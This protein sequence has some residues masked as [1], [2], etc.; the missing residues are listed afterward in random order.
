[1]DFFDRVQSVRRR[2]QT[3]CEQ[4]QRN[5]S[6]VRLVG[7]T[8]Y[9]GPVELAELYRAGVREFGENRLQVAKPKLEAARVN[10][11]KDVTWHFIGQ[12]QTN[13]VKEVLREFTW[14]HS[15][16]RWP[17]ALEVN[18]RAQELG[19]R[20]P[21]LLQIN[22]SG[23]ET[24]AGLAA[25]EALSFLEA[26]HSLSHIQVCGLMTMAPRADVPEEI[27]YVFRGLREL[28]DHLQSAGH[29]GIQELSMGMSQDFE[30]AILEGATIVRIGQTLLPD[31]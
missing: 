13:K 25:N 29:A 30:A 21:C 19:L 18:K 2:I 14:I 24:K 9:I 12:L 4:A 26:A 1:M 22:V 28:R 5:V 15:L 17:L 20:V 11:W 27:R 3:A 31:R 23:E 16:D 7:V 6:S 8:K 10:H